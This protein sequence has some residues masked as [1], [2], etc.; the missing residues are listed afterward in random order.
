MT[1]TVAAVDSNDVAAR[2]AEMVIS[3]D[4]LVSQRHVLDRC[5]GG[6]E[7]L[8][9]AVSGSLLALSSDVGGTEHRRPRGVVAANADW[10]L[11]GLSD[12]RADLLED[13]L[14]SAEGELTAVRA[15]LA[16]Q[17]TRLRD[18]TVAHQKPEPPPDGASVSALSALIA[19]IV[20]DERAA[21]E[22]EDARLESSFHLGLTVGVTD[23]TTGAR[24][25]ASLPSRS[26]ATWQLPDII[27]FAAAALPGSTPPLGSST[28]APDGQVLRRMAQVVGDTN[29]L[30]EKIR[31]MQQELLRMREGG[32]AA[33]LLSSAA[34]VTF[35]SSDEEEDDDID[36]DDF[37]MAAVVGTSAAGSSLARLSPH[38]TGKK[39]PLLYPSVGGGGA[40][41][42]S[43]SRP[44]SARIGTAGHSAQAALLSFHRSNRDVPLDMSPIQATLLHAVPADE[45]SAGL[46]DRDLLCD[47]DVEVRIQRVREQL[48]EQVADLE[49]QCALLAQRS[50]STA[51]PTLRADDPRSDG[52]TVSPSRGGSQL[53]STT[54]APALPPFR[55]SLYFRCQPATLARMM[56][57]LK[58]T[59]INLAS[60]IA[61]ISDVV[62]GCLGFTALKPGAVVTDPPFEA[63]RDA[64]VTV[65]QF[66]T[67]P[68]DTSP[69]AA[70]EMLGVIRRLVV[71]YDL[72][73]VHEAVG[74][75]SSPMAP[76]AVVND[77][78]DSEGIHHE[79]S[80]LFEVA[81]VCTN[82]MDVA[83]RQRLN[84]IEARRREQ[85]HNQKGKALSLAAL[86][87][88][89]A[90]PSPPRHASVV[91]P[92]GDQ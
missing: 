33:A 88:R 57:M 78:L 8:T 89:H 69:S 66:M 3:I 43:S 5:L 28:A 67:R 74:G 85:A 17:Q 22:Q 34:A 87:H 62:V 82:T 29:K 68:Y 51:D 18:L 36:A 47:A 50:G 55:E 91:Q 38:L 9:T 14:A 83:R 92:D 20:V 4:R 24:D 44:Q 35:V 49:A 79:A 25:A 59:V 75:S 39:S 42:C 81:M 64:F 21:R 60:D 61:D 84:R 11:G 19:Q 6:L 37:L 23:T 48:Q 52:L 27:P 53:Q 65:A 77:I 73:A 10:W 26:A 1:A 45:V 54:G 31:S 41:S 16:S 71:L 12:D 46:G 72:C 32:H 58:A 56:R 7:R 76:D 90:V 63:L 40:S 80:L 15:R 2:H 86:V 70:R 30:R 13:E